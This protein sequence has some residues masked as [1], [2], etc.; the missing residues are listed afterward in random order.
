[1][2][3]KELRAVHAMP[4]ED[5][6]KAALSAILLT[7]GFTVSTV[8]SFVLAYMKAVTQHAKA[9]GKLSEGAVLGIFLDSVEPKLMREQLQGGSPATWKAAA[10]DLVRQAREH[11]VKVKDVELLEKAWRADKKTNA[12]VKAS[13]PAN[14]AELSTQ[15]NSTL[16]G[17]ETSGRR[18]A[19]PDEVA[20]SVNGGARDKE[21]A[22]GA[23]RNLKCWRCGRI[24]GPSRSG[25]HH[26]R[27]GGPRPTPS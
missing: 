5:S 19:R 6:A 21:K 22:R 27:A 11:E 10:R 3:L 24:D 18:S 23:N 20:P 17:N 8:C 7:G 4:G 16:T 2:F 12:K 1:M 25:L 15:R 26:D 14:G 9:A 13:V